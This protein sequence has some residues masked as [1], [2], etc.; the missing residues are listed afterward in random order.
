MGMHC[1]RLR[2]NFM[3]PD[4]FRSGFKAFMFYISGE[5]QSTAA[6]YLEKLTLRFLQD[7]SPADFNFYLFEKKWASWNHR[8]DPV[9]KITDLKNF[10]FFWRCFKAGNILEANGGGA[11]LWLVVVYPRTLRSKLIVF[12]QTSLIDE[13]WKWELWEFSFCIKQ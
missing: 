10:L 12:N 1:Y 9:G 11:C 3:Q 4:D 6:R 5:S 7:F 2:S 13:W 8:G